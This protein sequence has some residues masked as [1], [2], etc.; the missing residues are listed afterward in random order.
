MISNQH[1]LKYRSIKEMQNII[2]LGE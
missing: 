1:D 2:G